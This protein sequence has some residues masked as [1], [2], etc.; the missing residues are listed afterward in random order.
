MTAPCPAC[1]QDVSV[2]RVHFCKPAPPPPESAGREPCALTDQG[3]TC[4]DIICSPCQ[5]AQ[6]AEHAALR[7]RVAE[8][9]AL[10][11]RAVPL[12]AFCSPPDG[13]LHEEIRRALAGGEK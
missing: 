13:T 7:A 10:L 12:V 2:N 4:F 8:Y 6:V 3:R 1:G 11:R 5:E 9:E